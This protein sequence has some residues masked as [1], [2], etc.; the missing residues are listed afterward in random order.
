MKRNND[1]RVKEYVNFSLRLEYRSK[2]IRTRFYSGFKCFDRA[3][4]KLPEW[5]TGSMVTDLEPVTIRIS[6]V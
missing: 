3:S 1:Y 5:L 2:R 6:E 4:V